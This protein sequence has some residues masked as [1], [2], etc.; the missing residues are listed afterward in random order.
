[1][2]QSIATGR[3]SSLLEQCG[4]FTAEQI[5]ALLA[6]AAELPGRPLCEVAANLGLAKESV[7]LEALARVLKVPFVRLTDTALS[8]ELIA[9]I[10]AK[11]VFQYRVVPW[12]Q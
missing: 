11:A 5:T 7:L 12:R 8:K 2:S 4:L 3:I 9:C 10:P 1:M 6:R